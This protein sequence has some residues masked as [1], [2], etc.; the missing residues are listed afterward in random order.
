ME[1]EADFDPGDGQA[2]EHVSPAVVE[3]A[4]AALNDDFV[5]LTNNSVLYQE[6]R[7]DSKS[8]RWRR[9]PPVEGAKIYMENPDRK[10]YPYELLIEAEGLPKG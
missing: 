8:S 4:E 2:W 1:S 3:Q 6:R 10:G 5:E 9:E 7:P